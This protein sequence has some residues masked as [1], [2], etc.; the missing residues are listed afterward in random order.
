[1]TQSTDQWIAHAQQRWA[2]EDTT[3]AVQN[4]TSKL[5]EQQASVP[6]DVSLNPS[7]IYI[8]DSL[9]WNLNPPPQKTDWIPTILAS[10]VLIIVLVIAW[11]IH[12]K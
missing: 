10:I 12:S 7:I 6:K 9:L 11:K 3:R 2:T 5:G 8:D 1:M 4:L